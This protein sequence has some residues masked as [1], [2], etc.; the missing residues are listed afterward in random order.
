MQGSDTQERLTHYEWLGRI[1]Q[2][3]ACI[4]SNETLR[5]MR[6]AVNIGSADA[7]DDFIRAVRAGNMPRTDEPYATV[8][9][10]IRAMMK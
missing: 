2:D 10:H 9:R 8:A 1:M 5:K 4:V 6:E 3:D 7:M